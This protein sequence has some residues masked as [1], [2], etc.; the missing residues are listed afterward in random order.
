MNSRQKS[1]QKEAESQ[2]T[3]YMSF[4]E[5]EEPA[6][7]KVPQ[8]RIRKNPW[9]EVTKAATALI[10]LLEASGEKS[11]EFAAKR[12]RGQ[13][14]NGWRKKEKFLLPSK[15][16]DEINTL[17]SALRN[18]DIDAHAWN[19]EADENVSEEEAKKNAHFI[20]RGKG[21]GG[22]VTMDGPDTI[23][24]EETVI[25]TGWHCVPEKRRGYQ[26]GTW[27][28]STTPSKKARTDFDKLREL[29]RKPEPSAEGLRTA[30]F[31]SLFKFYSDPAFS[32]EFQKKHALL[33]KKLE[34]AQTPTPR[35]KE[36][37]E[38][39]SAQIRTL[40]ADVAMYASWFA[41]LKTYADAAGASTKLAKANEKLWAKSHFA[42]LRCAPSELRLLSELRP[43]GLSEKEFS[44][45]YAYL[46]SNLDLCYR[47]GWTT[48]IA[49][50]QTIELGSGKEAEKKA[51]A[52][53]AALIKYPQL[54]LNAYTVRV[55]S[56]YHS[57]KEAAWRV[58]L[59]TREECARG[60]EEDK[61]AAA[62]QKEEKN[63]KA[64]KAEEAPQA[65]APIWADPAYGGW[66]SPW[67][68][69]SGK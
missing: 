39:L 26:D 45:I 68:P 27:Y 50:G 8:R 4:S 24:L 14:E 18:R 3:G 34:Q 6:P 10:S 63:P 9:P 53:G 40:E 49:R 48:E 66:G 25:H 33:E 52:I 43:I 11:E 35:T 5:E 20:L 23:R 29:L 56:Y 21:L 55:I 67:G 30:R 62:S 32:R 16:K 51:L 60:R 28:K 2:T 41:Q 19:M 58:E 12:L 22:F 15:Y 31:N 54:L 1:R 59:G 64:Q 37:Q 47:P 57:D 44:Q 17:V 69:P 61:M 38:K 36:E 46:R 13:M 7:K 42:L 65:P